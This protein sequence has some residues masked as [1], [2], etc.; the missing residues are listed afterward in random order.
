MKKVLIVDGYNV[1][2]G[3]KMLTELSRQSLEHSRMKLIDILLS[4]G[5][6]K[7]YQVVLVFDG[8]HVKEPAHTE[9]ISK[10][11]EIIYTGFEETADSYIEKETYQYK[12]K[13]AEVYVV[14]SDGSEQ[15]QILGVGAYRIPVSELE[16]A[17]MEAK[18]EEHQ[19]SHRNVLEYKRNEMG[20]LLDP[21]VVEKLEKLRSK[22]E[23]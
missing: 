12:E 17:V 6:L 4:Y 22:K 19:Y 20:G 5:K 16:K 15:N 21:A 23:K 2:F 18:K 8:L 11:F 1:I 13:R 10:E 7:G 3:W 14:T 9:Q